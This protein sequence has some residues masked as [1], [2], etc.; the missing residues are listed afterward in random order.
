MKHVLIIEKDGEVSLAVEEK[1]AALGACSFE[2]TW[3][4]SQAVAAADRRPP[5]LVV[6]GTV[7][8]GC[9]FNAA[10]RICGAYGVPALLARPVGMTDPP[11]PSDATLTGPF[12]LSAMAWAVR[13]AERP[14][15]GLAAA[16]PWARRHGKPEAEGPAE[17]LPRATAASATRVHAPT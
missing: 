9:P 16:Q 1:L 17:R 2:R 11:P 15:T 13:E 14:A 12:P 10:R 6:I 3:S 4:E 5:D 7:N 8:R